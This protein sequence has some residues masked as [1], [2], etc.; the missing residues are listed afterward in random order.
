MWCLQMVSCR[1][2]Q[3]SRSH[4]DK[5]VQGDEEMEVD[6]SSLTGESLPVTIKSG[7][8]VRS[9]GIVRRGHAEVSVRACELTQLTRR[10]CT[11]QV[12]VAK[13]GVHT[14]IGE[15]VNLV[16]TQKPHVSSLQRVLVKLARVLIIM[17]FVGVIF[18]FFW[19]LFREQEAI[20]RVLGLCLVLLVSSIPVAMQVVSTAVLAI[21]SQ[22]LARRKVIV[23]RL[24]AIEELAGINT[25]CSD[26]TGTLTLVSGVG[27]DVVAHLRASMSQNKLST[28]ESVTFGDETQD[29]ILVAAAMAAKTVD[30]D[31]LDKC[32]LEKIGIDD[33]GRVPRLKEWKVLSFSPFD[34]DKKFASAV[35]TRAAGGDADNP[36]AEEAGATKRDAKKTKGGSKRDAD[37]YGSVDSNDKKRAH[38]GSTETDSEKSDGS[39]SDE[40]KSSSESE[41]KDTK[42]KK[43]QPKKESSGGAAGAASNTARTIEVIKGTCVC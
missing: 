3:Q 9:G 8:K 11:L 4:S 7:E 17:S 20:T 2:V 38:D 37:E 6:E 31:A 36:D 15:A 39:K 40:T 13:T 14:Y 35:L 27:D 33:K 5:R 21:G 22:A 32:I 16:A 25:L 34:P 24:S 12:V 23:T 10:A 18:I 43:E 1:H 41:R 30:P 28:G 29:S 26:K 42:K 19:L